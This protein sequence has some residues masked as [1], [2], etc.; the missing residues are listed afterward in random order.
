[1]EFCLEDNHFSDDMSA[2]SAASAYSWTTSDECLTVGNAEEL[3]S[4]SEK[5]G[6]KTAKSDRD[7]ESEVDDALETA[8]EPF[9]ITPLSTAITGSLSW[10]SMPPSETNVEFPSKIGKEE[11]VEVSDEICYSYGCVLPKNI[12]KPKFM[13]IPGEIKELVSPIHLVTECV[14]S[15]DVRKPTFFCKFLMEVLKCGP[16]DSM[17]GEHVASE[18]DTAI[19][20]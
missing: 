16:Q 11:I 14:Y 15:E 13:C 12:E 19:E 1:M 3:L 7:S 10:Y 9:V 5:S 4:N 18:Y 8:S 20:A 2:A 17:N 6:L